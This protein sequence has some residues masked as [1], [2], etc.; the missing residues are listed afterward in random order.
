MK[1]FMI[2]LHI[3]LFFNWMIYLMVAFIHIP[4]TLAF[5]V[6]GLTAVTGLLFQIGTAIYEAMV[7]EGIAD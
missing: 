6:W 3:I 5:N 4:N 1:K 7:E 2:I